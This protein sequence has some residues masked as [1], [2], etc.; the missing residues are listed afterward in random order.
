MMLNFIPLF[1]FHPVTFNHWVREE[2]I[3]DLG[4]ERARLVGRLGRE[5]ELEVLA[6]THVA[7]ARVPHRVQGVG[8]RVPLR[9]EHRRLQRDEYA[10]FHYFLRAGAPPPAP[11]SPSLRSG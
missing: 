4:R 1:D 6:L 10:S 3:G 9:V 2:L 8:N 5:L 11:T 7:D